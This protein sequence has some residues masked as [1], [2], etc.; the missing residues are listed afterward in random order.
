[1]VIVNIIAHPVLYSS[2]VKPLFVTLVNL[3]H[4]IYH[5]V[6]C[7]Y[8]IFEMQWGFGA[9]PSRMMCQG[10]CLH[11]MFYYSLWVVVSN[12]HSGG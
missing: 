2:I 9:T 12:L 1:M 3:F 6:I 10:S 4:I 8:S 7:V 11:C 5:G